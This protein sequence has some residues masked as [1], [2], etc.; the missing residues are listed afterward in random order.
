MLLPI[1]FDA[2]KM[3]KPVA[4]YVLLGLCVAAWL[5]ATQPMSELAI[6]ICRY[7]LVDEERAL[8]IRERLGSR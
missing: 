5:G 6:E 8:L 3:R 2:P 1:G 7:K 4:T